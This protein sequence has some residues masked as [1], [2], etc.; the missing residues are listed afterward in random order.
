MGLVGFRIFQI[1]CCCHNQLSLLSLMCFWVTDHAPEHLSMMIRSSCCAFG[2]GNCQGNTLDAVL[3]A[4]VYLFACHSE[5][6]N[7]WTLHFPSGIK[8]SER[9]SCVV[10]LCQ[11]RE[12]SSFWNNFPIFQCGW[13][14]AA[15][16]LIHAEIFIYDQSS[17]CMI[18]YSLQSLYFLTWNLHT[19]SMSRGHWGAQ[20]RGRHQSHPNES[21]FLAL[22]RGNHY[23]ILESS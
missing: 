12:I 22:W 11:D 21:L 19:Y 14:P 16:V 18:L 5:L 10:A 20:A 13:D 9:T 17:L 7:L 23:H 4:A 6:Y 15:S 1:F 2:T 3:I 8:S